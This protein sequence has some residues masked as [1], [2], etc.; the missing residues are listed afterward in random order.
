MIGLSHQ[1]RMVVSGSCR[2]S[3]PNPSFPLLNFTRACRPFVERGGVD[4][5]LQISMAQLMTF[6]RRNLLLLLFGCLIM[7]QILTWRAV[8]SLQEAVYY[9]SCGKDDS[10]C[11]VVV[12]PDKK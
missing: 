2:C 3:R 8:V 4:I 10:P 6:V 5:H 11:K 9:Y 12:V 7:A 1:K